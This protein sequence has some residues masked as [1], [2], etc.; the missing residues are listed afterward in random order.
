MLIYVGAGFFGGI[1]K[2]LVAVVPFENWGTRS[3]EGVEDSSSV[4]PGCSSV[5]SYVHTL[6]SPKAK[7]TSGCM[8]TNLH[9]RNS[10]SWLSS[11]PDRDGG[12]AVM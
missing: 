9:G 8:C 3:P 11:V 5:L 4:Y 7:I 2:G 1:Q 6:P 10:V 12:N